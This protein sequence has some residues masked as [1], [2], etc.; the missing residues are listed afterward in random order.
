[1]KNWKKFGG[2]SILW[3]SLAVGIQYEE[4][5]AHVHVSDYVLDEALGIQYEE[6]KD[7]LD[8]DGVAAVRPG[9]Q[10]EELKDS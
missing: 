4:L 6:L 8:L 7:H 3:S 10:Y 2:S 5:K 1:M 9:I